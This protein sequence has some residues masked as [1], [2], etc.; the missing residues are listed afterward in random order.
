[1]KLL[2]CRSC[3]DM[4]KLCSQKRRC[5]CGSSYGFYCADGLNA[6][7]GGQMAICIGIDNNEMALVARGKKPRAEFFEIIADGKHHVTRSAES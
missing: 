7:I 5:G 2:F 1:M 4:I 6:V 3:G